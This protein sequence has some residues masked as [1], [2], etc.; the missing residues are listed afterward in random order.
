MN[1]S[2]DTSAVAKCIAR[3]GKALAGCG[4]GCGCDGCTAVGMKAG[5]NAM[6]DP[7]KPRAS[8]PANYT[9]Y[10]SR[11]RDMRCMVPIA[12]GLTTIA[13]GATVAVPVEPSRGCAEG[14]YIKVKLVDNANPQNEQRGLIG[15]VFVGT[16]CVKDC[17]IEGILTDFLDSDDCLG[18]TFRLDF[19]RNNDNEDVRMEITNLNAAGSVRAQIVVWGFCSSGGRCT[20]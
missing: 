18:C 10:A 2:I 3:N 19:G 15:R 1:A 13:A 11:E 12:S 4:N 6:W 14:Y 20:T 9:P 5:E 7:G 17:R 16:D 8:M